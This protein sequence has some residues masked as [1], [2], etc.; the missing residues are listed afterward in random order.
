M[1]LSFKVTPKNTALYLVTQHL[2]AEIA[3]WKT[4]SS[5]LKGWSLHIVRLKRTHKARG[6]RLITPLF[7]CAVHCSWS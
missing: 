7:G 1:L 2:W 6:L 3:G 4:S 5:A